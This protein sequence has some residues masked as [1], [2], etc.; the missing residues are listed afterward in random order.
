MKQIS[1]SVGLI[2]IFILVQTQT[3]EVFAQETPQYF[4]STLKTAD[5]CPVTRLYASRMYVPIMI[6]EFHDPTPNWQVSSI[7]MTNSTKSVANLDGTDKYSF[8]ISTNDTDQFDFRTV[9][10]YTD[11]QEHQ[12]WVE[13]W[14]Q[15]QQV[16]VEQFSTLH[17]YFCRDFMVDT[18][19]APTQPDIGKAIQEAEAGTFQ[20]LVNVILEI[21][22]A[23]QGLMVVV[24]V[25]VG[26]MIV[27]LIV[28]LL[29][30]RSGEA[31]VKELINKIKFIS[32]EQQKNIR[33]QRLVTQ[34]L[35]MS[36]SVRD[37]NQKKSDERVKH[38]IKSMNDSLR[39]WSDQFVIDF[40]TILVDTK[41]FKES[42]VESMIKMPDVK[43]LEEEQS[44][45]TLKPEEVKE[46]EKVIL[47]EPIPVDKSKKHSKFAFW[48]KDKQ[49]K[50]ILTEEEWTAFY[51][52]KNL[53]MDQLVTIYK[54][55]EPYVSRNYQTD[56][57][58]YNQLNALFHLIQEFEKK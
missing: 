3:V 8:L 41:L 5:N 6:K 26:I 35:V 37:E 55:R 1:L 54:K 19:V 44:I 24:P 48:K 22:S 13:Y 4:A 36:E 40:R 30:H 49:E 39:N 18:A 34:H 17:G 12:I 32:N 11:G 10:S 2:A 47:D 25:A 23:T 38:A 51:V 45:Q 42:E 43:P 50:K 52:S 31:N 27:I 46:I 56:E 16:E 57:N 14:S 53:T 29:Y 33:E 15:N 28:F 7:S 21:Q 58:A 9:A 20:Q